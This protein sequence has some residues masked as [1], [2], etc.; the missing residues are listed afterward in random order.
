M[1]PRVHFITLGTDDLTAVRRFY[2]DGLGWEPTWEVPDVVVF[3]QVGPGLLLTLWT[4][5]ELDADAGG[6]GSPTT[7]AGLALAHNVGSEDEV[8]AVMARA[9]AAGA[10]I[11][12]PA[13]LAEFGGFHG[14]FADPSGTR[15]EVAHNPGWRVDADG[16]VHIGPI[17]D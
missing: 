11:L 12:K 5:A 4:A 15:W 9:E 3:L 17:G 10:T 2:V 7:P 14:Y 6:P 8:V 16:T 1:E 13:Q